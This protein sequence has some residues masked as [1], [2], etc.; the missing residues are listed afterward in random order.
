VIALD[1]ELTPRAL[2]EACLTIER[3]L[4]RVRDPARAKGPRTMDLDILI[5]D[6]VSVAEPDLVLPHPALAERSFWTE[7]LRELE[8]RGC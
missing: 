1:T 2:L 4:G 6:Q 7:G 5:Y 3:E 8:A